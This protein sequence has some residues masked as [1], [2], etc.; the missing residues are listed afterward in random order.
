MIPGLSALEDS[1]L[2]IGELM[3]QQFLHSGVSFAEQRDLRILQQHGIAGVDNNGG[4]HGSARTER[5]GGKFFCRLCN[6]PDEQSEQQ[7]PA[8]Q[9]Q[10]F[11]YPPACSRPL[12][13]QFHKSQCAKRNNRRFVPKEQMQQKRQPRQRQGPEGGG[14]EEVEAEHFKFA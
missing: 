2:G 6:G 8:G 11:A 1:D 12:H 4:S 9:Q 7:S 5:A 10:P 14:E 3:S 13:A